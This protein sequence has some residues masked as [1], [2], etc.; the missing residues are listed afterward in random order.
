[1]R[2]GVQTFTI[3]K[4][5]KKNLESSYLPLINMGIFDL[6]IARINFTRENALK[7]RKFRINTV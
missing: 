6:E 1:M 2:F 5:Q 7:I 4:Y 3:R